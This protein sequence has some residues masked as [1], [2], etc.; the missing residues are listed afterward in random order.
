MEFMGLTFIM[1]IGAALASLG[2]LMLILAAFTT[3]AAWGIASIIVPPAV[4]AFAITHFRKGRNGLALLMVGVIVFAYGSWDRTQSERLQ[5]IE[6]T[7]QQEIAESEAV[8]PV[9]P[10]PEAPKAAAI[11]QPPTVIT[12]PSTNSAGAPVSTNKPIINVQDVDK[13][14]GKIL[15]V[16]TAN[17]AVRTGELLAVNKE[18]IE[19]NF[20]PKGVDA[21]VK[22]DI[23]EA[24]I[25][26]IELIE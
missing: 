6:A 14:V 1:F 4:I 23:K 12:P 2:L 15:R 5:Q 22:A 8:V 9:M 20:R 11:E 25:E 21:L 26:L 7:R 10:E 18:G 16:T 24:E 19:I 13:Y 3:S 17:G